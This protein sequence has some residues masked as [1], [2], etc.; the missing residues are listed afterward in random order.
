VYKKTL[1]KYKHKNEGLERKKRIVVIGTWNHK[2][3]NWEDDYIDSIN[4]EYACKRGA[5]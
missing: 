2:S 4:E 1:I 3:K 5:P